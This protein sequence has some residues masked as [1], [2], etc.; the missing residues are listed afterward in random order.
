M[1]GMDLLRGSVLVISPKADDP[2]HWLIS[3]K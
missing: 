2:I 3:S 1:I